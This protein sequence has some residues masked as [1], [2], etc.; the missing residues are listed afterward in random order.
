MHGDTIIQNDTEINHK[1]QSIATDSDKV[2]HS[3]YT[4]LLTRA[5]VWSL[6][7]EI[8]WKILIHCIYFVLVYR[9]ALVKI[10]LIDNTFTTN[11]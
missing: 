11:E 3:I 8:Y 6:H 10:G 2:S 4:Q 5:F 9:F 1:Q 7:L